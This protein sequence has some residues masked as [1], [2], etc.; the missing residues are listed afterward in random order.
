LDKIAFLTFLFSLQKNN[1]HFCIF[2]IHWTKLTLIILISLN[3]SN[4]RR[5]AWRII[6][7]ICK[8]PLSKL[9][10]FFLTFLISLGNIN[11]KGPNGFIYQDQTT[12]SWRFNFLEFYWSIYSRNYLQLSIIPTKNW[13]TR[14][15]NSKTRIWSWKLFAS[16]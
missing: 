9:T 11:L 5:F 15:C 2:Y 12:N 10:L 4:L 13:K 16:E 8:F 6:T 1:L 3:K 7:F 14:I